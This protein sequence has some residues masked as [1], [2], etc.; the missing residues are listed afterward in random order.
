MNKYKVIVNRT[1]SYVSE[2][3]AGSKEDAI[4]KAWEIDPFQWPKTH[5]SDDC[6]QW[7][8]LTETDSEYQYF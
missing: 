4:N 2:V 8:C 7:E 5:L 6:E 3:E 1:I